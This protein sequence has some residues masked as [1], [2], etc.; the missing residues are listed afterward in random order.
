M[1]KLGLWIL[2]VTGVLLAACDGG[3]TTGDGGSG[4]SG[5]DGGGATTTSS[6]TSSTTVSTT[7]S[8]TSSS[9]TS[10][11]TTEVVPGCAG[12]VDL[13][14][15][16]LAEGDL[17]QPGQED[18]Y[19]F[20]GFKGQ[21]LW[22]DIDAQD[23]DQVS[24]DPTYIDTVVTL[25]TE[26]DKKLAQNNNPTEFSTADSR[27]YTILPE[28]G[29]YCLRVAECNSVVSNPGA[30]CSSD[31]ARISSTFY[32]M[33]VFELIDDGIGDSNTAD[34]EAGNDPASASE[35]DFVQSDT[36]N[37]FS[38]YLWG[39]YDTVDDIDVFKFTLPADVPVPFEARAHANFTAFASGTNG[40]GSS[41]PTGELLV[42]DPAD[43]LV[44]VARLDPSKSED[45]QV[46]LVLDKEYW[47]FVNRPAGTAEEN[48]FYF[49]SAFPGWGNPLEVDDVANTDPATPEPLTFSDADS[50][51]IEGDILPIT[52]LDH[53][54]VD[55]PG[56]NSLVTAV[57][58]S[59]T[60]GS[61]LRQMKLSILGEDGNL[62]NAAATDIETSVALAFAQD[63]PVGSN[64]KVVLRVEA[65]M[66][67]DD[68]S[69]AY[70]QCG[71]HFS[72]P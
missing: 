58:A 60:R 30:N 25:F 5:G 42:F 72:S 19:R 50:A 7:S 40:T 1:R 18:Y 51:F 68:T 9:T 20:E 32:E 24:F 71:V 23:I 6:T 69:G 41:L 67:A 43:M 28:D 35:V 66:Q 8:T 14:I 36:G 54:E 59:R 3:D 31:P 65:A 70:Y 13:V 48:D 29:I 53:F 46:P 62:L 34:P 47:L 45:L 21:V 33:N 27:L 38:A 2:P 11:S 16:E 63:I 12:G 15:G 39:Y 4:G 52:D 61:G 26:D 55:V 56:G 57:C 22:I 17:S 64:T 37:Y 44:P 10:S 49:I